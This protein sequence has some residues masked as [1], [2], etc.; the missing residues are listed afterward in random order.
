MRAVS[1]DATA[2]SAG[3]S[4]HLPIVLDLELSAERTP[5][6][7]DEESFAEEIGRRHGPAA[8]DVVDK[9]VTWADQKERELATATGVRTKTLTRFPTNGSTTEPELWFQVDLEL[10]PKGVQSTISIK[11]SGEVVVQFGNMRHPPF[12]TDEARDELRLALNEM[13]GVD[14]PASQLRYWPKFPIS[15]LEEPANLARL[16]AVLDRIA[17][18]SHAASPAPGVPSQP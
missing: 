16:V 4:D 18:E 15:V 13:E 10:E 2:V 7:W 14:I 11:A 12:D 1:V 5:H 3:L 17:M 8:R 6:T 9:L